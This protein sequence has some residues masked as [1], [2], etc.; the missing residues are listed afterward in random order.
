MHIIPGITTLEIIGLVCGVAFILFPV[1]V[2]AV[3][4]ILDAIIE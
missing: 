3:M 2:V 1:T 4:H